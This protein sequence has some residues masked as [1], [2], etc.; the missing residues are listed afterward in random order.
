MLF[1]ILATLVVSFTHYLNGMKLTAAALS[2][3]AFTW[4]AGAELVSHTS[5][6]RGSSCKLDTSIL[7][8]RPFPSECGRIVGIEA[9]AR[10]E[11]GLMVL[12]L[13]LM[14]SDAVSFKLSSDC[15]YSKS[16]AEIEA[17]EKARLRGV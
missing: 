2:V 9:F 15:F 5:P 17:L 3:L 1:S 8:A 11:S 6:F 10:A 4:A 12:I 14:A 13:M 16:P 7:F